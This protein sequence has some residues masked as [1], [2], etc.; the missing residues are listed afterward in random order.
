MFGS[1]ANKKLVIRS[2]SSLPTADK[3]AASIY[4]E[5]VERKITIRKTTLSESSDQVFTPGTMQ[6]RIEL[7]WELSQELWSLVPN[8]IAES[9]VQRDVAVTTFL[10]RFLPP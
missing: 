4:N 8:Q 3:S 7:A 5:A 2:A 9:R 1:S 10:A 6:S